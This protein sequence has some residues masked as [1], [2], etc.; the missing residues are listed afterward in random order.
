LSS[1]RSARAKLGVAAAA[2]IGLGI[3]AYFILHLGITAV[4][5]AAT[6][7]GWG[8]FGILCLLGLA[9]YAI[10]GTAWFT[11]VPSA[12][13]PRIATFIWGRAVR[14]AAAEVLPFS[15]VGGFVIGAR[16]V[17]LRGVDPPLASASMIVDVTIEMVA[18]IVF[19]LIAIAIL[20]VRVPA[21]ASSE[22]LFHAAAIGA[23]LAAIGAAAFFLAQ[24]QGFALAER[25][26]L[27]FLP[28]AAAG[29]GAVHD[30]MAAIH[31]DPLR[32][33]LAFAVHLGGWI[34]SAFG[35][36]AAVRLI[37]LHIPFLSVLA[38]EALLSAIRSA[39]VVI[40]NALGI[41]EAG[42]AMLAPFFGLTAQVGLAVSLLR[43]ARDITI[44]VPVLL[45][46][47]AIEGERALNL[48]RE[49]ARLPGDK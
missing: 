14:D 12:Y 24:K 17:I 31:A 34:A 32:L 42:Y 29:A 36:W 41:Q 22:A 2:L 40:P 7:V 30:A 11:L 38:I 37:G 18:Q 4:F 45:A 13:T 49:A 33:L 5:A 47:Q 1:P 23:A 19:V 35:T 26:A 9:L 28:G 10:L 8:G 16:A 15:Q 44:G 25:F 46:W 48:D 20:L 3:A 43:R 21:S 39:A 27:R 6:S